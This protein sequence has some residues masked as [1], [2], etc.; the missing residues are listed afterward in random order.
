LRRVLLIFVVGAA[1]GYGIVSHIL[2]SR[3]NRLPSAD[4]GVSVE[5]CLPSA[6]PDGACIPFSEIQKQM[7]AN[8]DKPGG[9]EKI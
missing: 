8:P 9:E 3:P 2:Q 1:L 6:E 7:Q 5:N 4:G